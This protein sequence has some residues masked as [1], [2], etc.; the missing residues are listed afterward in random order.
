[1]VLVSACLMGVRCRYDG[2]SKR[3][4]KLIGKLKGVEVLP[5]CPEELG[6]LA[7]PRPPASFVGGDGQALLAGSARLVN[8]LGEDV[9]QAYRQGAQ[10]V[11]KLV[12]KLGVTEAYLKDFS[13]ACGLTQVTV[14]GEGIQGIG[15][16]AALLA[17]EGLTLHA[18]P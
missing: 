2:C 17:E 7:T 14:N 12:R 4:E 1:M 6:G 5:V 3:N 9:T 15:I 8:A 16:C 13:P 11:L 18:V 10:E